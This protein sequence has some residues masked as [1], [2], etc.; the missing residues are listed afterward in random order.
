[1]GKEEDK[2][3][4]ACFFCFFF[5]VAIIATGAAVTLT[6][7]LYVWGYMGFEDNSPLTFSACSSSYHTNKYSD[8]NLI[9]KAIFLGISIAS[10]A[11]IFTVFLG[12]A[13]FTK[14]CNNSGSI[15]ICSKY[16]A[17]ILASIMLTGSMIPTGF[18]LT[19]ILERS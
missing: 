17:Y 3:N 4:S 14:R 11:G 10:I 15:S 5:V 1:M 19:F 18:Y 13:W 7:L 16:L 6:I 8:L 9:N 12:L 2:T